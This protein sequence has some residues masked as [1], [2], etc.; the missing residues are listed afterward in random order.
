MPPN[1]ETCIGQSIA[2]AGRANRDSTLQGQ[3]VEGR[4]N[5]RLVDG[6]KVKM[7]KQLRDEAGRLV[8]GR[9]VR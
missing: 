1:G 7:R 8:W 5:S 3:N 2:R 4:E 9:H 6:G